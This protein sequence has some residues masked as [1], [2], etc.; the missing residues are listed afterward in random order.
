MIL[1][2]DTDFYLCNR[3]GKLSRDSI[4]NETTAEACRDECVDKNND[5]NSF[6][7]NNQMNTCQ[8]FSKPNDVFFSDNSQIMDH[9]RCT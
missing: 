7:F 4:R 5:Y 1:N 3:L 9:Y 2:E 8:L 6:D